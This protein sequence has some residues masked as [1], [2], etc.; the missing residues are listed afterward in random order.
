V[1]AA[2]AAGEGCGSS[3]RIVVACCRPIFLR[4]NKTKQEIDV[5]GGANAEEAG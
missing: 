4:E 2:A 5:T 3:E 1:R